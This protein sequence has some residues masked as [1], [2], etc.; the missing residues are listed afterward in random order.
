MKALLRG[1]STSVSNKDVVDGVLHLLVGGEFEI[2]TN[3]IIQDPHNVLHMLD[4]LKVCSATLQAEIWS[5]FTAILKK[6]RRNLNACTEVKLIE[7][8][9]CMLEE[10]DDIVADLLVEML[11]VLASYSITVKELRMLF[12]LLKARNNEWPRNSVKL[13]SVLRQM[14]QRHGPDEFFS[15]PGKKGSYIALPPIRSWPYQNGWAFS[16]W[17]RLDPVTGVTVE[18]EKPYLYCFRTSKGV[19]YSAHFLGS[20]LVITSMK[21]KG[22]GFQH[23]V[24]YE[25]APRKWYMVTVCHV[26]YRWSRSE[27]RCYVDGEL[28]SFTDMSWLVSTNDPFD[29]CFLGASSDGD[30]DTMFCGQ[31]SAVYLFNEYLTA[32]QVAAIYSL[33]PGYK[34]QFR[35]DNENSTIL[36]E[37][38]RRVLYEG[39]LT[40]CIVFMYNPV[41]CDSQLCL[42]SSPKGNTSHFVHS[43]HAL[44][45]QD[46]KAIITRSLLS[47]LHSLGG[48]EVLFPLFGQLD[49]PVN[50]APNEKST[51]DHSICANLM[52]LLCDLLE[53]SSSIQ[54]ELLQSKGFL[55]ISYLLE[56]SSREHITPEVLNSFL[57]LTQ[58]LVKLPAGG[59]LLKHLFDH[60]LFNPGLWIYASVEVQTKLY[61]YLATEFIND[62]QI[63][64]SIRRVSAVL[65]T[66]HT[67][68]YYYWVVNP[69]DRSGLTPRGIDGPRPTRD[70][71]I[72][73]RSFMLLYVKELIRKGQGILEDE[74]QSIL[75]YLTTL[76]EDDNLMDVLML[77][78]T[79]MAQHP[80]SMVPSFDKKNGIRTVFKLLASPNEPLRIQA[81][82][83]LGFFLMRSTHKRK[84]DAMNPHN[85]FSLIGERLM[86]NIHSITIA[87]YNVLFE[88]L[89]ERLTLEYSHDKHVEP[90]SYYKLENPAILKVVATMIRQSKHSAE[91]MEVKKMFLSDLTIM[92]NNNKENRR[93]LL[94]MSVWQE[95]LFSM[96]YIY[97]RNLDEQK[98]TDMVMS[99]FRM[100]L[101]HA[102]KFEYGGWR[103]WVDTL[104]IL[105]SKVAYEDFR[106]H[107]SKMYQQYERQRVENIVDPHERKQHPIS[108][109]SGI[110]DAAENY[111]SVPQCSVKISEISAKPDQEP[112]KSL[113]SEQKTK[114]GKFPDKRRESV[115][116]GEAELDVSEKCD[117]D[118]ETNNAEITENQTES[119]MKEIIE[120]VD[121]GE[122]KHQENEHTKDVDEPKYEDYKSNQLEKEVDESKKYEEFKSI[123]E[124]INTVKNDVYLESDDNK[125]DGRD[126]QLAGDSGKEKAEDDGIETEKDKEESDGQELKDKKDDADADGDDINVKGEK[127][128]EKKSELGDGVKEVSVEEDGKEKEA[129]EKS[130]DDVDDDVDDG[131]VASKKE[132]C[133]EGEGDEIVKEHKDVVESKE[134]QDEGD[135]KIKGEGDDKEEKEVEEEGEMRSER[136]DGNTS[137]DE[138]NEKDTKNEEE[139]GK[140]AKEESHKTASDETKEDVDD[141]VKM[142]EKVS[143]EDERKNE[144]DVSDKGE[145]DANCNDGRGDEPV[146][147]KTESESKNDTETSS[148]SDVKQH[149]ASSGGVDKSNDKD[150][151]TQE[152]DESKNLG[153]D[154][155]EIVEGGDLS[156]QDE[157]NVESM[158]VNEGAG[159][160]EGKDSVPYVCGEDQGVYPPGLGYETQAG[161]TGYFTRDG[162]M[163]YLNHTETGEMIYQTEDGRMVYQYP[164]E[165]GRI[166]YHT[167]DADPKYEAG[168]LTVAEEDASKPVYNIDADSTSAPEEITNTTT[169]HPGSETQPNDKENKHLYPMAL[170]ESS[171]STSDVK[172]TKLP[173]TTSASM[174]ATATTATSYPIDEL[175][176]NQDYPTD[177]S[178]PSGA[179]PRT[180]SS[181]SS[182]RSSHG[183]T[184]SRHLF[185]PGPRA[186]PF[187][188]PEFRWSYLHQKLL[189]DLLFSIETDIQVWKSHSTRAVVDFVNSGENHIYIV[190]VT[191]MISQLADNLIMSCGG[192]LPL[193][194][195][196]TSPNGELDI[197]E[198][199]QGLSIEQAVSILQRI[200]NMTDIVVFTSSTNFS[201][202]EQEK[203]M[204]PGGILRQCLR[205]VCTATVRNCLECKHRYTPKT[206]VTDPSPTQPSQWQ[207]TKS[208]NGS[209]DPIQSLI[210]GSHPSPKNIVENLGGQT[211][212][213]KDAEKLLQDMDIT[214]L[215][216][217][218]YRDMDET[219]QAQFLAL[220]IV[221]FTSVLMVSKYRDILEPPSPASTPTL[222]PHRGAVHSPTS[223]DVS[224]GKT[225]EKS[226]PAVPM[227]ISMYNTSERTS[228]VTH[229]TSSI[230]TSSAVSVENF[231]SVT[232][233]AREI[234]GTSPA[235]SNM[236]EDNIKMMKYECVDRRATEDAGSVLAHMVN[237]NCETQMR[238][239]KMV[240]NL[241]SFT[242]C[243]E[244]A[245]GNECDCS[246]GARH[247]PAGAN[248]S[249]VNEG[250][251]QQ[252]GNE[253]DEEFIT[254]K[255][256]EDEEAASKTEGKISVT[257]HVTANSESKP[258]ENSSKTAVNKTEEIKADS[259]NTKLDPSTNDT[260]ERETNETAKE[261]DL[262]TESAD[263][264]P[265]SGSQ[266][267]NDKAP[268]AEE[269]D[270]S[271][272]PKAAPDAGNIEEPPAEETGDST[273]STGVSG[274]A[275]DSTSVSSSSEPK[276]TTSS[277]E[278]TAATTVTTPA[279]DSGTVVNETTTT[280]AAETATT[281]TIITDVKIEVSPTT[282]DGQHQPDNTSKIETSKD[283]LQE[284]ESRNDE[285]NPEI[286]ECISS[287]RIDEQPN[288]VSV[289]AD[290]AVKPPEN[291]QLAAN[292]P[293]TFDN[294][295]LPSEGS[296]LT[297][298]L[299]RAL[300]SSAPL[301]REVFVD[302]APFLSKTLIGSHGQELL[303]GGLVTLKQS[304][305]V[306]ELVML[307]CSQEW[308]NSLQKHAGL[309]FIELVNE[310]RLLAHATRD[311]IV[312]VANEAEFILTRMRA[313]DVQKHAE[314]ESLCAQTVVE[315]KEEEKLCDH[316]ITSAKRRDHSIANVLREKIVNILTNKHGAWGT[317]SNSR[318]EFW[319]LDLWEDDFRRR[320]RFV[321]NPYG[322]THPEATLKAAIEHG[323][324]EDAINQAWEAFHAHLANAKRGQQQPPDYTDEELLMEERDFEQE[325]SGPVALSTSCKLISLGLAVAGT[326]S[327]TKTDLYFEMDEEDKENKKI[328]PQVLAYVDHLHG[329]WHFSEI[330]AV[331]SRRYLLQNVA[332]E[333]FTANRTAVM[334]AFP[335][336]ITM[337]KVVNALPRVGIGIRYGLNQARRMSLASGKQLFKL[338]SMTQKWQRREISNFDYLI[339]LNTVAGRTYNDLNQYPIFP[340]VIVN[341]ESKELDLS[342]PSNFRD[343]SKPIGALNPA[344]KKF[345][346][347]R[348][349]TWEH[350]QIPPFHY[351]THY[352]TA[353]FTLNWLI[354]LEP[355]TTLFLNM[356]GGKFDHANRTFFSISQAWKNCQRDTSDV[357]E[358]IPEFY[359]LPE[360]FVNQNTYNFGEQDDNIKVDDVCLPHWARTPD[361]FVRI[362]RMALESEFVSCQLHHW[363]DLIFGYKQRGPEAVR[364]T[365][366]FYYLTYEGSVN[367]ESMTDPVM[368]EAIENQI[369]SFGQT[370]TQLLT[371]PHPPRSSLMHLFTEKYREQRNILKKTPMMFS[372]V[373]D[374]LCMLMKFLSNSPI[375]HVAANTHPMVP[376]PAVITITCNHNFA[377]NKWNP[378]YQQQGTPTSFSSDK[379]EKDAELPVLMDHLF[380]QNT[381]LHRRTL[382]DN[383]DQ[384]LK[385]THSSFVTTADNRFIFACGFW[386][387]SFRIFAT[388]YARI[389]QVIYGHFDIVTCITKSENNTNYDCYIVTG[390]KDCTVMVWQFN[391]RNQAII[392]DIGNA[393]FVS[394]A[395]KPT[396]KATLTGHQ[397]EVICVAVLS[398]LGLVISGSRNGPCL[399]HTLTGDLL[400]SLD[401]PK[402]CFSPELITMSREAFVLVKFDSGNIC[403]FTVN[404]RLLQ[405]EKHKDNILTMIL[406]RGGEYLITGGESG[407][408]DVWRT[409]D[410]TLLYSYPKCDGSIHSL[411][412]SHDERLLFLVSGLGAFSFSSLTSTNGIM[413][414][415]NA[416]ELFLHRNITQSFEEVNGALP[417]SVLSA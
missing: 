402:N 398:E 301:L 61:S 48:I 327:I 246:I 360:M 11:G 319:K 378:N 96:A 105:H 175:P 118:K 292:I 36:T 62:A 19:G 145:T 358:L 343:L 374:D 309:A 222:G 380:A 169:Q 71:I 407:V 127:G 325:F 212:P 170:S 18:K 172:S 10:A 151:D 161:P 37:N 409:H 55:V 290:T 97:P 190:N 56:K 288:S 92:C 356:Q 337:K 344:R 176:D 394:A 154:Q 313:E 236:D 80:S 232:S 226:R 401:P 296:S 233:G 64:N 314:F 206:P 124:I 8:V 254:M 328:S 150:K 167:G 211:T 53:S 16:C 196:A 72:K 333:I 297:E 171:S 256:D 273:K 82:K 81:L 217:V 311:H 262:K 268:V 375:T 352:S 155:N 306:V 408:A 271:V 86:L 134:G 79:L 40:S 133:C 312:R 339:Y 289:S 393:V 34:S 47:T 387:K 367:L 238:G 177:S 299:E 94:Q 272:K 261:P 406:S 280:T 74:L 191:H 392:G 230:S 132:S 403:S 159:Y 205:L 354:R 182:R 142:N 368:K 103:V 324:T 156:A 224:D 4:V 87:T 304:S 184:G 364:A 139:E 5:V 68:K 165:D 138:D 247:V 121:S 322:S 382:G 376:T 241:T 330:R 307:L 321:K 284:G 341:Y 253:T 379:H 27:L 123:K 213:I 235:E 257:A 204:P 130:T 195:A 281:S 416:T 194:A 237:C 17:L 221:Y 397:T 116:K 160:D 43:P 162:E 293:A 225:W 26:Y 323:A 50:K 389:V 216:A 141:E 287:I 308:Q 6:S 243:H 197:L 143:S 187:R 218:V 164:T 266:D 57:K 277:A 384:R 58:Y 274:A 2:E 316:L 12:S 373:Q 369:R 390:S 255:D 126:Q 122:K 129:P 250:S 158:A 252:K 332:I 291:L 52:G 413:N 76:H 345:F 263:G 46:V 317:V 223:K 39:R 248:S 148:E 32:N 214:R 147:S 279:V 395:E 361:D 65:Q 186:P 244:G 349:A 24:K 67:L 202:L 258:V 98:I 275:V 340:W 203:N 350:E 119:P 334:F 294:L 163:I 185:S 181:G 25:F 346:D 149:E 269:K 303:V 336:H 95:W 33:G 99:L 318:S 108:T 399:V 353:A 83:L 38:T 239:E 285:E 114:T 193:L 264:K 405:Y 14:P 15:F 45:L 131:V 386:D 315:R 270:E 166:I 49:Y 192:L 9:L 136:A 404:G 110:S 229:D 329:K 357:K 347:E 153:D 267:N 189:S 102:I 23:C 300:G 70:E 411:S 208:T 265:T 125:N 63:Y 305:S 215:R 249:L 396:P 227:L 220:A 41:A 78:V 140:E 302:F 93:T 348:Y 240:H 410:L 144:Q 286:Q 179:K 54:E 117:K 310:G 245:T 89:T 381:G 228:F 351:G 385:V 31:M 207:N 183:T 372:S 371:E 88:I 295:P 85:L 282:E 201:E 298:R 326:M 198:P 412:L 101:H 391:A 383:F 3:F 28:V 219:K 104:A 13:L 210:G 137:V 178:L 234:V 128:S 106:L 107:M 100:L 276:A 120:G 259:E 51:I 199:N 157:E 111:Q 174:S 362:N 320:R 370:P 30:P 29:K 42:E 363:I 66:M 417:V 283:L 260:P 69:Y 231:G 7:H 73:L 152:T 377:V 112:M 60:I 173:A 342:Q 20:S 180:T 338:S 59:T 75:N 335:D 388:D 188:I 113:E 77:L 146:S 22:K 355:F 209:I 242:C 278:D 331:F 200:M 168:N 400:Q 84:Y 414:T 115:E 44:M 365:N 90:E 91:L 135:E 35:F 1:E 359:Y 366:V 21:L 251:S 415:R 109:I